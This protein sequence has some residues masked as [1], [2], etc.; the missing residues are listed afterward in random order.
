MN[1]EGAMGERDR[2]VGIQRVGLDLGIDTVRPEPAVGVMLVV[3]GFD[4]AISNEMNGSRA[5]THPVDGIEADVVNY[6]EI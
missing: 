2:A 4:R 5:V 3:V 6:L 1:S